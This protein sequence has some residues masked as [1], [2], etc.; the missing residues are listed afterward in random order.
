MQED[1]IKKSFT[2]TTTTSNE[3]AN[4]ADPMKSA[5]A[6]LR[7]LV[8][9]ATRYGTDSATFNEEM[10][11]LGLPKEHSAAVCRVRDEYLADITE[12]LRRNSL[13]GESKYMLL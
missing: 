7:F 11:Q 1:K 6:C 3:P 4:V 10:Q 9:N 8:V 5:F 12:L 13:T 2:T